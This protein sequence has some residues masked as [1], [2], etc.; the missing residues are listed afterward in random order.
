[1]ITIDDEGEILSKAP[2]FGVL[3]AAQLRQLAFASE[4]VVFADGKTIVHQGQ[5]A[6]FAFLILE[7]EVDI[8]IKEDQQDRFLLTVGEGFVLGE[9][10]MI[11]G[12]SYKGMGIAKG[13]VKA[14]R[15]RRE[16]FLQLLEGDKAAMT[17][18]LR[19]L[20]ET[21]AGYEEQFKIRL[22]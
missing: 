5:D 21:T 6:E 18:T 9:I 19:R 20:T 16:S 4:R 1:M 8:S 17:A 14:L 15:I 2:T 13:P 3:S 11:T 12:T 10:G 22:E 7:G